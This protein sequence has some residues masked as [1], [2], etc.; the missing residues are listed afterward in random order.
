MLGGCTGRTGIREK[1]RKAIETVMAQLDQTVINAL[2]D[3]PIQQAARQFTYNEAGPMNPKMFHKV[4]T[5]FVVHV[6]DQALNARWKLSR[7]PLGAAIS[8]LEDHYQSAYGRGYIA[9]VHDANNIGEWGIGTVLHSLTEIINN[10][11]RQKYVR[12]IFATTMRR[13][14]NLLNR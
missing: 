3:D 5:N 14:L 10:I 11:E 13:K 9:A 2:F 4:V 8:L 6:Y 12:G 7:D 1:A